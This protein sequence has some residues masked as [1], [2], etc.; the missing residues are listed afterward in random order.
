[1]RK[2][3]RSRS[4]PL[5]INTSCSPTAFTHLA[6]F[7]NAAQFE[8]KIRRERSLLM[9]HKTFDKFIS[10]RSQCHL[11]NAENGGTQYKGSQYQEGKTSPFG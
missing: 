11:A 2:A 9:N 1:R 10:A 7:L 6:S 4:N 3:A 5:N 8:A